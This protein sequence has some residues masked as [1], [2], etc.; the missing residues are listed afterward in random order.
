MRSSRRRFLL[1]AAAGGTFLGRQRAT[2]N[3]GLPEAAASNAAGPL[4]LPG[5]QTP[6][7]QAV[8]TTEE[9]ISFYRARRNWGRWGADD[10]VGAVNLITP[11]KRVAAAGLVKTGRTVPLGRVFEPAQ[12]FVSNVASGRPGGGFM[13]DYYGY[14]YHGS[15][16]THV[17][18]LCHSW[19][20][21]GMWNGRD[22]AKEID[23]SGARFGDITAWSG[24]LITRGVLLDVPR[25]RREP[26]V[27]PEKPV[28][29]WELEEIAKAQGVAVGA[30]DAL[31][32]YSGREAYDRASAAPGGRRRAGA[33]L[34]GSCAK[35][36]RDHDVSVLV[37]DMMDACEAACGADKPDRVHAVIA[38]F[39][40]CLV[41]NALLEP[42]AAACQEERRYEFMFVVLPL[43]VARGSGSA[44][45][46]TAIF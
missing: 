8:P 26:H 27:T 35:F 9:I 15:A 14:I 20:Q 22:P 44:A 16:I 10:Q 21:D 28:H 11:Q 6:P 33:G 32:I 17:D 13:Q 4:P 7:G 43:K 12:H 25:H 45:N 40:V 2:A 37:W 46:P 18:A 24:R 19:V 39:G 23:T 5:G 3:A 31:L 38:N 41:D 34:H 29:G 1:A 36:I 30:G 42:L